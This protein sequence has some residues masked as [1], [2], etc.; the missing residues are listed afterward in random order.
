MRPLR[1]TTLVIGGAPPA[2][3]PIV[4]AEQRAGINLPQRYLTWQAEDGTVYLGYN[5]AE[6]I[7]ARSGIP[8]DSPAL[9]GLR[10]GSARIAAAATGADEPVA[11]GDDVTD[12]G[13]EG[14]L[15]EQVSDAVVATSIARYQDAFTGAGLIAVATVDHAGAAASIGERLRLTTVTFAGNPGAGTPLLQASQTMGIDL[16]ARYLAWED[17]AG[18]VHVGHPDI[19]QIAQRR[20][21]TGLDGNLDMIENA[22]AMFTGTAAGVRA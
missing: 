5:T 15:V 4:L 8:A 3:T 13:P 11:P 10:T 17:E 21:V 19:R 7:G 22:T 16:P 12:V 9:D 6:Y 20:A 1:P 14:H 18:V 2:G